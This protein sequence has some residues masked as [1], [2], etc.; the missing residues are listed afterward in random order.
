MRPLWRSI[1][2]S[3]FRR[4]A[5]G[6]YAG[7]DGKK[8]AALVVGL[9][10]ASDLLNR[11]ISDRLM[12]GRIRAFSALGLAA[13]VTPPMVL[14]QIVILKL[15]LGRPALLPMLWHR[16]VLKLLGFRLTVHGEMAESAALADRS[17]PHFLDRHRG[18]CGSLGEDLIQNA[19]WR[20]GRPSDRWRKSAAPF[21]VKT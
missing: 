20:R 3:A 14:V 2:G 8:S 21:F 5:S 11:T 15:R 6:Y 17:K 7:P 4:Q 18:G 16:F 12:L 1:V 9:I 10:F 13:L 19:K